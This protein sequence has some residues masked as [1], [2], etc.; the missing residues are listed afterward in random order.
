M[1]ASAL[2]LRNF[3]LLAASLP[4][5]CFKL[6]PVITLNSTATP[7]LPSPL[8]AAFIIRTTSSLPLHN[9]SSAMDASHPTL[10]LKPCSTPPIAMAPRLRTHRNRVS[11]AL[12]AF[13]LAMFWYSFS[14]TS[15]FL[16]ASTFSSRVNAAHEAGRGLY[17]AL[18][19]SS[20]TP[21][22]PHATNYT[23]TLIM[24]RLRDEAET[25]EWTTTALTPGT[26]THRAIYIVDD[27]TA[28]LHLSE[29]RGRE[30]RVYLTYIVE[31]YTSLSDVSI[32]VHPS[33]HAW[34]NNVLFA[35]DQAAALNRLQRGY[36]VE[37]GYLNLRCDLY[38]G[39]PAWITP[40]ANASTLATHGERSE[41]LFTT[42]LW[43]T[44]FP[45]RP[46][47]ALLSQPCC[48]QFAVSRDT[49]RRTPLEQYQR[50]LDWLVSSPLH[51]QSTG[52]VMEYV[53]QYLFVDEAVRCPDM[54]TCY[55]KMY[56]VCF[57]DD[58]LL[59][60]YNGLAQDEGRYLDEWAKVDGLTASKEVKDEMLTRI[61]TG[62]T[63]ALRLKKAFEEL[64]PHL[65]GP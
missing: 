1:D 46:V 48:S 26:I 55:C 37:Q 18:H 6:H 9:T 51:D 7:L 5:I 40:D 47:P 8:P 11:A 57:E 63:E 23:T 56:D 12:L 65:L 27:P 60:E 32:F 20:P 14:S 35:G 21:T 15:A 13:L 58:S 42:D 64:L 4:D 24:G 39:C 17:H 28:P 25:V 43:A 2:C 30:A 22:P 3:L 52:R 49:I 33:R 31:H 54:R 19:V 10:H 34:H 45:G 36:V 59:R 53:W 62:L 61:G 29:N 50:I 44:L 38:P 16:S 41:R